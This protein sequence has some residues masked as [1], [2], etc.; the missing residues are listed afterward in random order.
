MNHR[1]ETGFTLIELM[2]VVAVVAI[3]LMVAVPAFNDQVRSSRRAEAMNAL[4]SMAL[5]QEQWRANNPRYGTL[6]EIPAGVSQYYAFT[7]E[8][9]TAANFRMRAT[10]IGA[11]VADTNCAFLEIDR[12]RTR[13]PADCWQR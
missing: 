7:I 13:I 1:H 3:L 8:E 6:A 2:I 9:A 12:A 11:Q 10:A 4:E 5:R